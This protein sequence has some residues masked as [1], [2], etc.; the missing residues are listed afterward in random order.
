[1]QGILGVY[2]CTGCNASHTFSERYHTEK[3][4]RFLC[5]HFNFVLSMIKSMGRMK[6]HISTSCTRCYKQY[7]S[8]LKMGAKNFRN[9]LIT[10][11]TYISM[12]CGNKLEIV[13]SLSE[14]YFDQNEPTDIHNDDNSNSNN[15]NINNNN[16][17]NINNQ[18]INNNNNNNNINNNQMN[19]MQIMMSNM[20]ANM[21]QINNNINM[22]INNMQYMN[23]FDS[24]NIME[25]DQ[26]NKAVNFLEEKTNKNYKIYTSSKLRL[27]TVL[28]DLLSL[29]PEINYF[30]NIL[31]LNNQNMLSLNYTIES[32][33]LDDNS[34]I[35]I[36]NKIN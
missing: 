15:I 36:K 18:N 6:F 1:M 3:V 11:D 25:L 34:I 32:L 21:N 2:S 30:N 20:I 13:M 33:N 5:P 9:D 4:R 35:V 7:N 27:S 14:E 31:A 10:E 16:E 22:Q 8:E 24:N 28:N 23:K 12:C 29:Y 26:K 19:Q 17:I